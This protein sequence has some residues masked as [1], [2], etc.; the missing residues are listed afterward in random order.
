[1]K[2]ARWMNFT[3]WMRSAKWIKTTP[4]QARGGPV[5][6]SGAAHDGAAHDGAD[7]TAHDG[8]EQLPHDTR[9]RVARSAEPLDWRRPAMGC[10]G[11]TRPSERAGR[12]GP[13]R[14]DGP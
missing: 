2:S 7:G 11:A 3:G 13:G 6:A 4:R 14:A 9:R 1:M 5:A 10:R 8:A 12:T